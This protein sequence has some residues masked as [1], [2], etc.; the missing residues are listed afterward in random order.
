MTNFQGFSLPDG[1]WIPPELIY[2]LPNI[3]EAELKV[4]IAVLY[5]N[6]QVGGSEPL[7]LRDV[8]QIT[9]MAHHSVIN[10]LKSLL[11]KAL[12]ERRQE[13]QSF[14]Y[15]PK[16]RA[17]ANFALPLVQNLDSEDGVKLR[18]SGS[19]N[20]KDSSDSLNLTSDG[21]GAKIA[22]IEELRN[23][24]VYLKTAQELVKDH[25]EKTIHQHFRFYRY[26]LSKNLAQGPGWLVLSVKQGWGAPLGY[27]EKKIDAMD[28]LKCPK[29]G[30]F[31]SVCECGREREEE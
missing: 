12:L 29:C 21:S 14:V 5:H 15:L 2:L 17:S 24:G 18:E 28:A 23:A 25:S 31:R 11:D 20:L 1:A 4:V 19:I 6:L 7:S 30:Q 27:E 26:A 3:S 13:G 8:E 9:G 22:L 16:I 10:A